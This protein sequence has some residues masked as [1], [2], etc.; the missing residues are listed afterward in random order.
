MSRNKDIKSLHSVME[1]KYSYLRK[2]LK[3]NKWDYWTAFHEI[4]YNFAYR[5]ERVSLGLSEAVQIALNKLNRSTDNAI[6]SIEE[7]RKLMAEGDS[8][9][10]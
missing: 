1:L 9:N 10:A 6:M 2:R 8:E 5:F 7:F 3:A 4:Q